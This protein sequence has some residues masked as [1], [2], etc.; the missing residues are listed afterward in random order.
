MNLKHGNTKNLLMVKSMGEIRKLYLNLKLEIQ[1]SP[2]YVNNRIILL[3][4]C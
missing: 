4:L 3:S 2:D 1:I